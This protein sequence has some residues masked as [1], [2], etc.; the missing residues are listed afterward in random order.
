[1]INQIQKTIIP[2]NDQIQ[3]QICDI[4]KRACIKC[5]MGVEKANEVCKG[6]IK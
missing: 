4:L 6:R 2:N 5:C 3:N 1:M